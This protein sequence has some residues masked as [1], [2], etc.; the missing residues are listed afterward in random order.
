MNGLR[1]SKYVLR[2]PANEDLQA[3]DFFEELK[4]RGKRLRVRNN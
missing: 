3:K 1:S 4:S 2:H